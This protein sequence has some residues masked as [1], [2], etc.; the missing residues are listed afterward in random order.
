M[1]KNGTSGE[2]AIE[3]RER[4]GQILETF[5]RQNRDE[6]DDETRENVEASTA[7]LPLAEQRALSAISGAGGAYMIP[8]DFMPELDVAL[9]SNS[10]IFDG[11]R[12]V[13]TKSGAPMPFPKMDD[14]GNVGELVTENAAT[15]DTADPVFGQV[16][17]KTYPYSS[18][19]VRVPNA[20][21]ADAYP[22]FVTDLIHGLAARV[23]RAFNPHGTTGSGSSQPRGLI[24]ALLADTTPV[25][26]ASS[27]AI[28]RGDLVKLEH[29]IDPAYRNMP[30]MGFM[31][32][33]DVL[34]ALDNLLD[35]AGRPLFLR[36]DGTPARPPSLMGWPYFINQDMDNTIASGK[37]TVVFGLLKKYVV[38]RGGSPILLRLE[39]RYAEYLQVGFVLLERLDGQ[40]VMG[41]NKAIQ[42]LQHP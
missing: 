3:R 4:S 23:A 15:A 37:E 22:G 6:W 41:G 17:L 9:K 19:V 11:C 8:Q 1:K 36:G 21:L 7:D 27:V 34:Q 38:R 40:L 26:A 20:L 25:A 42:V 14:T 16:Q 28:S 39:E 29:A 2:D 31:L 24:T 35:A 5:V 30:G 13:P 18:K 33:Y 12:I 10:G 32:H